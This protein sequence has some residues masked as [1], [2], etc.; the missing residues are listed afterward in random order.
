MNVAIYNACFPYACVLR[1]NQLPTTSLR[2]SRTL[3]P[4]QIPQH[5]EL[6]VR[7]GQQVL[8]RVVLDGAA[9]LEDQD[10]VEVSHGLETVS[11][12]DGGP[13]GEG[14]AYELVDSRLGLAVKTSVCGLVKCGAWVGSPL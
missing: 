10:L 8:R 11:D 5:P 13:V 4:L 9:F 12:D 3:R 7:A 6:G 14:G 1:L 2:L